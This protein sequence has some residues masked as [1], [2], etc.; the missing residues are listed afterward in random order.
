MESKDFTFDDD[1]QI[2]KVNGQRYSYSMFQDFGLDGM[3]T[4]TVFR[5]LERPPGDI[6]IQRLNWLKFQ[7]QDTFICPDC[8]KELPLEAKC[9][10]GYCRACSGNDF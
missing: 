2:M 5:V 1:L 10:K 4:E 6:V 8:K 7:K 3:D 9:S